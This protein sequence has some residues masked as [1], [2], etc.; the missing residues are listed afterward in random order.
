MTSRPTFP[1]YRQRPTGASFALSGVRVVDFTRVLAGPYCTQMLADLGAD[2]IKIEEV[3]GGDQIRNLEP[4]IG[5]NSTYFWSLNRNKRSV[6]VDLATP[7]GR[8]VLMDLLREADIVV[9][10]YTS[11]VM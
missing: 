10:N 11:R 8:N 2:V 9:E 7:A 5:C 3:S 4:K 1:P 6:A